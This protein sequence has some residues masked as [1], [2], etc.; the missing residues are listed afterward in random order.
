[1]MFQE[2]ISSSEWNDLNV[3]VAT[4][5]RDTANIYQKILTLS[6][7]M[8]QQESFM[9]E[10]RKHFDLEKTETNQTNSDEGSTKTSRTE[11]TYQ[12]SAFKPKVKLTLKEFTLK[13]DTII[14]THINQVL[15][16]FCDLG[17]IQ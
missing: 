7:V 8:L 11:K 9:K 15:A 5:R 1:M 4:L 6:E 13:A 17:A 12:S 14:P 2:N 16:S 3:D 10:L